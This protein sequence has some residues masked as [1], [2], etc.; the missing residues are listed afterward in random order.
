MTAAVADAAVG[1]RF[2]GDPLPGLIAA[3]DDELPAVS[4]E[5]V[6]TRDVDDGWNA[7]SAPQLIFERSYGDGRPFLRVERDTHVGYR[8]WAD[9]HGSH[10][11]S[12]D[13][14]SCRS[15]LPDGEVWRGLKLLAAQALPVLS[16]LRG[17]EVLHSAGVVIDDHLIGVVAAAGTGKS[18][19]SCNLIAQGGRFFA[20]DVLAL[21][22]VDGEV[23]A[24]PGTLLLNIYSHEYESISKPGRARLGERLGESDK[25]H[26]A[27][28]GSS[29]ALPLS[30]LVFLHRGPGV[31]ATA[32]RP[33]EAAPAQL[34]GNA[35]LPYLDPP[36]RLRHQLDVMSALAQT[37]PLVRL[38]IGSD[39]VPSTLA[40]LVRE[41]VESLP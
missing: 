10:L 5:C 39:G 18:T 35:F 16:T 8:V 14:H 29:G 6:D 4:V 31:A 12:A 40:S 26:L 28:E 15:A 37:V 24:H 2:T 3:V 20:D 25:V 36:E 17:R 23:R 1:L 21:E 11:L 33:L 38:E 30:G 27:P 19:T 9:E 34:L 32:L 41:W 22:L 7:A 13:G